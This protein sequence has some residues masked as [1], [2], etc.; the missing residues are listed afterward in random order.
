[1]DEDPWAQFN[2]PPKPPTKTDIFGDKVREL[3]DSLNT[4]TNELQL[5]KTIPYWDARD[6]THEIVLES[7]AT[8]EQY[9]LVSFVCDDA[10]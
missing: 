1:M 6:N 10:D 2:Q 4:I 7:L 9:L 8:L 5:R 3:V